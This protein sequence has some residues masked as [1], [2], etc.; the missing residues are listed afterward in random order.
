MQIHKLINYAGQK[1]QFVSLVDELISSTGLSYSNYYEL[2]L[3]SGAM[4]Y[5]MAASFKTRTANDKNSNIIMMHEALKKCSYSD[6]I[7][8][9]NAIDKKFGIVGK[10][11]KEAYYMFRDWFNS[12]LKDKDISRAKLGIAL[13]HLSAMCI[14]SMLRFGPNGMNQGYGG[15]RRNVPEEDW[16]ALK[17]IADQTDYFSK[18]YNEFE[19]KDNSVVF[20]DP[21]YV[22]TGI[23]ENGYSREEFCEWLKSL[24]LKSSIIVYTDFEN[25]TSDQLLDVGFEKKFLRDCGTIAPSAVKTNDK[26]K[27][28]RE[29]MY[30]KMT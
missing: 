22:D 4:L 3:G 1:L 16:N 10:P 26:K 5:N 23:Y 21:P 27:T 29:V 13:I 25:S 12:K 6:Y 9:V 20:L 24:D 15:R 7:S 11:T 30:V 19:I 8:I 17:L 18:D 28:S 2:F 14:N